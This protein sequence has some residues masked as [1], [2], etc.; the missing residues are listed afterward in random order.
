MSVSVSS[1]VLSIIGGG[2]GLSLSV[3]VA[4]VE[5]CAVC[6]LLVVLLVGGWLSFVV[7]VSIG[8][9]CLPV[10]GAAAGGWWLSVSVSVSVV[11]GVWWWRCALFTGL[12]FSC[13]GWPDDALQRLR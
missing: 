7:Y 3:V 5:C 8:L 10:S 2:G 4:D 13:L 9:C 1:V 11:L 12:L 6:V